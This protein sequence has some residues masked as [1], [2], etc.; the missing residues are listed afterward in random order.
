MPQAGRE[1]KRTHL[2]AELQSLQRSVFDIAGAG[3]NGESDRQT[4]HPKTIAIAAQALSRR[5][6]HL[7]VRRFGMQLITADHQERVL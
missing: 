4:D 2:A 7:H 6:C 1:V 5:P 3:Y